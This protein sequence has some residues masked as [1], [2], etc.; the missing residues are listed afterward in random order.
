MGASPSAESSIARVAARAYARAGIGPADVDLAEVHDSIAFNELLACEELG[1]C[2]P[3]KGSVLVAD[4]ATR[5]DGSRPV[6]PS[7]GLESRGHPVAATGLAQVYELVTQLRGEAGARQVVDA[8]IAV[9]ENAG[10]FAGDDTAAIAI[11][12]LATTPN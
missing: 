5:L 3:G 2:E 10:G 7:G 4:G 11:T 8:R 12:V 1:F 9:A 6:N